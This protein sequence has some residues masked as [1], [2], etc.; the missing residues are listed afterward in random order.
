MDKDILIRL[1]TGDDYF[2][3]E[4]LTREAFWNKYRPKCLEHYV[5]HKFRKR[6]DFVKDLDFVLVKNGEIIGH[7]MYAKSFITLENGGKVQIL[8][9]GPLSILPKYQH[10]GFGKLL[11][12]F[13]MEKAKN[14]GAKALAIEGDYDY[15]KKFGFLKGKDVGII[16]ADDKDA[17]YFLVKELEEDF[18]RKTKG[19]YSDPD[20]YFVEQGEVDEFDKKFPQKD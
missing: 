10:K 5:L 14:F 11:L 1:E 20:G 2:A 7:I 8:T 9:F 15:Y 13:S 18:L 16:Y 6:N 4:N 3:V 12:N 19:S 17:D